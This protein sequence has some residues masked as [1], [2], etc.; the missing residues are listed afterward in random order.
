MNAD[1]GLVRF[2]IHDYVYDFELILGQKKNGKIPISTIEN[3]RRYCC[4]LCPYNLNPYSLYPNN[5]TQ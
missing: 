1:N 2:G 4:N 5:F 3:V